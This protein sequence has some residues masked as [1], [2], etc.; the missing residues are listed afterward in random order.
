MEKQ[1]IYNYFPMED[2]GNCF[3]FFRFLLFLERTA[4]LTNPD[5]DQEIA[6]KNILEKMELSSGFMN[7]EKKLNIPFS[8]K[9]SLRVS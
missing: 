6:V 5:I 9:L 3:I 1:G 8:S 4:L 2:I 7:L